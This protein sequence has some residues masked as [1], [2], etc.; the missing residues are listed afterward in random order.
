[1]TTIVTKDTAKR[2]VKDIQQIKRDPIDGIYYMH[3]DTSILKGYALIIGPEHTPYEG[4]YYLFKIDFSYDYPHSPP[5]FTFC[6]NDGF[7]RMH[8]NMYKNGKVCLSILNTWNGEPWTACQTLSSILVTLRSILTEDPL[9]HEPGIRKLH[10][11]KELY[12]FI[13][14]YK[15]ISLSMLDVITQ[16]TYLKEFNPLIQIA[17][18]DFINHFNTKLK[19]LNKNSKK[20]RETISISEP[21]IC[22][23]IYKLTCKISY[24]ALEQKMHQT[25]DTLTKKN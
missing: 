17:R 25:Y 9:S 7:T 19:I 5:V 10:E 11:E 3:D 22:T 6:T 21:V 14:E 24:D 23:C 2:I 18:Q 1:M 15:N 4:G 16:E 13:I 20:L 8:P 12:T